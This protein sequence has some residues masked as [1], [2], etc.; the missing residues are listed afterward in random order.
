[1]SFTWIQ[2]EG[3][4]FGPDGTLWGTGYA[5]HGEGLNNGALQARSGVGPLPCGK[6][7]IGPLEA[8]HTTAEGH[9]LTDSMELIPDTANEMFGRGGFRLHGRKSLDDMDASEGCIV[10]DHEPRMR[11]ANSPD[12]ALLVVARNPYTVS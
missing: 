5:G 12:K 10:L 9:V 6:Y 7:T 2:N 3:Q 1:M 4:M 8:T 11:V